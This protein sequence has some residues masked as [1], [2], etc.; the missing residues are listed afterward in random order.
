[1]SARRGGLLVAALLVLAACGHRHAHEDDG[2]PVV[3]VTVPPQA[4]VV[5]AVAGGLVRV[6]T[7][8]PGTSDPHHH[9]PNLEDLR[10]AADA[11]LWVKVGHPD[12]SFE[13]AWVDRLLSES[14]GLVV[15]DGARGAE[16]I[17]GDPHL[18]LSPRNAARLA[19]SVAAA[20]VELLPE[21]AGALR[22]GRDA[23]LADV[24]RIESELAAILEPARG[25]W[26]LVV[27]P[28]WGYLVAGHGLEQVA[29]EPAG[30]EPDPKTLG[31]L[32]ARA[33]AARLPVVFVEPQFHGAGARTVADEIGARVETVD[34]LA[35]DWDANLLRVARAIAAGS[36]E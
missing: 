32:I 12:F 16:L 36:A 29:I 6:E 28:A 23:F 8:L 22:A 4:F 17:D 31:E 14:P 35:A 5:E 25:R 7:L 9:E 33:R 1:M 10:I 27:H 24:E 3:L 26:F 19:E 30:R 20:L 15:V 18:W 13:R 2:R 21:Q 34:P 11:A